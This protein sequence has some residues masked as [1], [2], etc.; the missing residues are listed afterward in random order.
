[1]TRR[2]GANG[3]PAGPSG[4]AFGVSGSAASRAILIGF[5]AIYLVGA[6]LCLLAGTLVTASLFIADRAPQSS[7]F[8]GISIAMSAIF[9]AISL[10]LLAI[11][12][13][14]AALTRG[15]SQIEDEGTVSLR[16]N[17]GR[18]LICLA[19]GGG[20]LDMFLAVLTYAILARIDQGFAVFG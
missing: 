5:R 8:L 14:A 7:T 10:L 1:M 17:A 16:R 6:A 3:I 19:L 12:R 15:L 18:L 4:P 11:Q 20:L 13:Q 2:R 9:L